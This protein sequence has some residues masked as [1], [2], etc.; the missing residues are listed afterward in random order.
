MTA[1]RKTFVRVGTVAAAAVLT[2]GGVTTA[3]AAGSG[4]EAKGT[5]GYS[6]SSA[7]YGYASA[8]WK[9]KGPGSTSKVKFYV[10]DKS[11]RDGYDAFAF[12]QFK[13]AD[14][15]VITGKARPEDETCGNGGIK[16]THPG[17]SD[18]FNVKKA[19]VVVCKDDVWG[20]GDTCKKGNWHRNP[21]A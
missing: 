8:K 2:A 12:M 14:G 19:R 9:W 6:K 1:T 13:G 20:S 7:G 10:K 17:F 15:A 11:C 16:E 4:P 3:Q 21:K 5:S 18:G